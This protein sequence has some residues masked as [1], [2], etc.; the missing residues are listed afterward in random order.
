MGVLEKEEDPKMTKTTPDKKLPASRSDDS[1]H[2]CRA[3]LAR[4]PLSNPS[5]VSHHS[6][7]FYRERDPLLF[8]AP[9]YIYAPSQIPKKRGGVLAGL[10][11]SGM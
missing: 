8:D 9:G 1:R 3:S 2:K 4:A 10:Q 6:H 5:S 7:C 11:T